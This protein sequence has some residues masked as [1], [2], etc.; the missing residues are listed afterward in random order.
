MYT[1]PKLTW[2]PQNHGLENVTPFEY[3]HFWLN[4][5][6]YVIMLTSTVLISALASWERVVVIIPWYNPPKKYPK[7]PTS[8]PFF[9]FS[10]M[11]V[12]VNG[13]TPRSSILIGFSIINHPFWGTTIFILYLET[14]ICCCFLPIR[15]TSFTQIAW[16]F[17]SFVS[18]FV[19]D[20]TQVPPVTWDRINHGDS[21]MY[22]R[23]QRGPPEWEIRKKT[24]LNSG[25]L[26]VII[27]KNPYK[28]TINTIS[29]LLGV[30]PIVPSLK[31]R[32]LDLAMIIGFLRGVVIPLI[33]P[34]VPQSSQTESLR[35]PR[36]TPSLNTPL[37]SPTKW[38][39]REKWPSIIYRVSPKSLAWFLQHQQ[40]HW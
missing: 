29:T 30:H 34:K 33:F 5:W 24:T 15:D 3:G 17:K 22:P 14:P 31:G 20:A 35:F 16:D 4:F 28:N 13:G 27:L 36:N 1:P 6:V 40:Y 26:W 25:Y 10:N 21:W 2:I 23:S 37:K 39:M 12:S 8:S 11:G 32:G 9:H 7:Q 19:G 38:Y 18:V